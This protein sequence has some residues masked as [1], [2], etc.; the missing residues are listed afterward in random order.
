MDI[1]SYVSNIILHKQYIA[2]WFYLVY[3][4]DLRFIAS[5]TSTIILNNST[6]QCDISIQN[7][8][9]FNNV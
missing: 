5:D 2:R 7:N 4:I 6:K 8:N 1:Q 3:V 9:P